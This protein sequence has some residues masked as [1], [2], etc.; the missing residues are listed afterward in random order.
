MHILRVTVYLGL[1][2]LS[3]QEFLLVS[4]VNKSFH[5]SIQECT[6]HKRKYGNL[7]LIS[8]ILPLHF[9][10]H[11]APLVWNSKQVRKKDLMQDY[12]WIYHPIFHFKILDLDLGFPMKVLDLD[13]SF[14]MKVLDLD[15]SFHMKVLDQV[16]DPLDKLIRHPSNITTLLII[17]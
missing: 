7:I 1:L 14:H 2:H 12:K 13:L 3:I 9:K 11:S 17:R 15:L 16:W 8:R 6:K 5:E 10:V 4:T